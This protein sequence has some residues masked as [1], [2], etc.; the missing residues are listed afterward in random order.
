[1]Q[2]IIRCAACTSIIHRSTLFDIVFDER[3]TMTSPDSETVPNTLVLVGHSI[4]ADLK[5]MEEMRISASP[6][7]RIVASLNFNI[8]LEIPHNVLIIDLSSF[9]RNLFASGQRG[10]MTDPTGH[11]RSQNPSYPLPLPS[12]LQ[13]LGLD[14]QPPL[15]LNNSG[16]D[17]FLVLLALQL[18]LNAQDTKVP[19][20]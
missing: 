9:E 3:S 2:A 14:V 18:L 4:S 7:Y 8:C 17:A 16:N 5:R 1:M 12:L 15:I 10:P 19:K 6:S 20:L 13:S 11:P